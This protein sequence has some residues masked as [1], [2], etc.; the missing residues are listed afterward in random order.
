MEKLKIVDLKKLNYI[1][2]ITAKSVI[3]RE[4]LHYHPTVQNQS[5]TKRHFFVYCVV[6][7]SLW[8][9][10]QGSFML[11]HPCLVCHHYREK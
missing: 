3:G 1:V 6:V 2:H 4:N 9:A 10:R 11:V 5:R 8:Q 7:L